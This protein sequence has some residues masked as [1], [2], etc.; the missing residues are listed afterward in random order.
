MK[1]EQIRHRLSAILM[2]TAP[3]TPATYRIPLGH[4]T[5]TEAYQL[6]GE[7]II[8]LQL[9]G[10][11]EPREFDDP[12]FTKRDLGHILERLQSLPRVRLR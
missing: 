12:E 4:Y 5:V 11:S 9:E 2:D 10:E 6:P 7:G 1:R 8:Y 3:D